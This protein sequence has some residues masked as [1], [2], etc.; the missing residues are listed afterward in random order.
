MLYF[1]ISLFFKGIFNLIIL[2]ILLI[3]SRNIKL[4][5]SYQKLYLALSIIVWS[6]IVIRYFCKF[7]LVIVLKILK[8]KFQCQKLIKVILKLSWI[9]VNIPAYII[10]LIAFI[11]DIFQILKGNVAYILYECIFC[12]ICYIFICFTIND[13]YNL[14][15]ISYLIC[16]KTIIIKKSVQ[17]SKN[18]SQTKMGEDEYEFDLKVMEKKILESADENNMNKKKVL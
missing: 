4:L 16:D 2:I 3:S 11:N 18:S 13:F 17:K 7:G 9:I 6:L 5:K 14:K 15:Y 8:I 1:Y 12:T 10:M